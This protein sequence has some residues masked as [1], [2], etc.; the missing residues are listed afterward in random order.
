MAW[1]F[2][3][4]VWKT[5]NKKF[6]GGPRWALDRRMQH[7]NFI[8]TVL[9]RKSILSLKTNFCNVTTK[10]RTNYEIVLE[11]FW[12]RSTRFDKCSIT[13]IFYPL[14]ANFLICFGKSIAYAEHCLNVVFISFMQL[15]FSSNWW[16]MVCN[17]CGG[18]MIRFF[19]YGL[20]NLF[21][22]QDSPSMIS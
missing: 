21:L 17:T 18:F 6:N 15:Q 19:P 8:I 12:N 9:P 1:M 16:N 4:N 2:N 5:N 14:I 3:Y 10:M 13:V 11:Y 20:K 7:H 22:C